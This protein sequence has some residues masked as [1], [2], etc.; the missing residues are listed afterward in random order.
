MNYVGTIVRF[1]EHK[2]YGFIQSP[3]LPDVFVHVLNCCDFRPEPGQVVEFELGAPSRI[4]QRKQA[5]NV[6]LFN[7]LRPASTANEVA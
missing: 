2:G 4:G 5:V 1:L 7:L 6:R 3:N